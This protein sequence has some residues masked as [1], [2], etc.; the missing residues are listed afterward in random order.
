MTRPS[1]K[2]IPSP[3]LA[4]AWLITLITTLAAGPYPPPPPNSGTTAVAHNDPRIQFWA[5]GYSNFT[6]GPEGA[7]FNNP[8]KALGPAVTGANINL[9]VL[10][11]VSLG[12]GGQITL[13][14]P[15]AITDG[16]GDDFAVFENSF[17]DTFLELAFVEV[18]ADGVNFTRFPSSSLT[19]NP[20]P[21]GGASVDTTNVSGL[22]GKYR[23]AFG[24]PFN[25]S[26]V[27]LSS[28][29]HVRIID[30]VG[31]GNTLDS[32]NNPIYDPYPT[33]SS[34]GFDLDAVAVLG[35]TPEAWRDTH[36]TPAELADPDVSGDLADPDGDGLANLAERA[37]NTNPREIN[38][39][40]NTPAAATSATHLQLTFP[41]SLTATNVT[42]H[43]EAST[44][45]TAWTEI[46]R[47]TNGGPIAPIG[48][49]GASLVSE[50]PSGD[51]TIVTVS[52]SVPLS[53]QSHRFLKLRISS[54]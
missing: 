30:I 27:G 33:V 41:R 15:Q 39:P 52:D 54:P 50:A 6:Q 24:T 45:L 16:P 7:S 32:S 36:F 29:T 31:D 35:T 19:A 25:L 22:A 21:F 8:D 11:I 51:K 13:T 38:A 12:R 1:H 48:S 40:S 42:I 9:D 14:F 43:V 34:A 17:N 26:D 37:L 28:A 4:A 3:V 53:N 49:P 5:S 44:D 23:L 20:V 10:E 47:G 46:A 18:S 2:K